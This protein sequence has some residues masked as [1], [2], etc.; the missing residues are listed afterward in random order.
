MFFLIMSICHIV[1]VEK[2]FT[3]E[4][5]ENEDVD[6]DVDDYLTTKFSGGI[7]SYFS[8]KKKKKRNQERM[9]RAVPVCSRIPLPRYG[10]RIGWSTQGICLLG[11]KSQPIVQ[12]DDPIGHSHCGLRH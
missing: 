10:A 6:E 8:P 12:S 3:V 11:G 7:A 1:V 4:I 9:I 2:E 5:E